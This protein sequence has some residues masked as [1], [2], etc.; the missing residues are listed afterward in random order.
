MLIGE[1]IGIRVHVFAVTLASRQALGL[2]ATSK[3]LFRSILTPEQLQ[4]SQLQKHVDTGSDIL[5]LANTTRFECQIGRVLQKPGAG[6]KKA[7]QKCK[8]EYEARTLSDPSTHVFSPLWALA[9]KVL[10]E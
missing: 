1:S 7:L 3:A 5:L 4:D 9:D 10:A 6:K 8:A 2:V